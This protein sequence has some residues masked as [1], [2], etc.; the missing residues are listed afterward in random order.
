MN[1]TMTFQ[2]VYS[3]IDEAL[4]A[5][6]LAAPGNVDFAFQREDEGA[7]SSFDVLFPTVREGLYLR[8]EGRLPR[9]ETDSSLNAGR[10]E[11][12]LATADPQNID[13]TY[14]PGRSLSVLR[15]FNGQYEVGGS[16]FRLVDHDDALL[17]GILLRV[18]LSVANLY[19]E[20]AGLDGS[21][22]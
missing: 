13:G 16:S 8:A 22:A 1:E 12:S 19:N 18:A 5:E 9:A 6:E 2:T 20:A 17:F 4:A 14:E 10:C 7:V 15:P 11:V 3:V 21:A